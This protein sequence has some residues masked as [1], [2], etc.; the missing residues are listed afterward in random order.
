[1]LKILQPHQ[2]Y[3]LSAKTKPTPI[4]PSVPT[5]D[6]LNHI[7]ELPK[8]RWAEILESRAT[9]SNNTITHESTVA[10]S[11]GS[12]RILWTGSA[13]LRLLTE[14]FKIMQWMGEI[15]GCDDPMRLFYWNV[16]LPRK[17]PE[18]GQ[19]IGPYHVNG[20]ASYVCT[21]AF[22]NVFRREE[23]EKVLIHELIHALCADV[24]TES[25]DL[26]IENAVGASDLKLPEAYTEFLAE[27]YYIASRCENFEKAWQQQISYADQLVRT[28]LA[29]YGR[30]SPLDKRK[31]WIEKT[32]VFS[33]YIMKAVLLRHLNEANRVEKWP[34]WLAEYNTINSCVRANKTR[35]RL[36]RRQRQRQRQRRQSLKMI[37]PHLA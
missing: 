10:F 23:A 17:I 2:I 11:S 25:I 5:P 28:I 19:L 9:G 18:K 29:H 7:A 35:R 20:G 31:P 12:N 15:Y 34:E 16:D 3:L 1:M 37:K 27:Y 30:H 22:I 6:E 33:Y 21:T 4:I 13:D 14:F 8:L 36:R 32:A 26:L 24:N